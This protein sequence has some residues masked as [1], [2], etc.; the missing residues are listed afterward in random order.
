MKDYMDVRVTLRE[1][2]IPDDLETAAIEHLKNKGGLPDGWTVSHVQPGAW[3]HVEL[4]ITEA[5]ENN[6]LM[7][8]SRPITKGTR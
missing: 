3:R 5:W 4:D 6:V 7:I 1:T 2:E 8:L